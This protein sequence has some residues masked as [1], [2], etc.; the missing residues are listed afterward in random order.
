MPSNLSAWLDH[1]AKIVEASKTRE[2]GDDAQAVPTDDTTGT[3]A[4]TT[5]SSTEIHVPEEWVAEAKVAEV[6]RDESV[7]A[8]ATEANADVAT[9]VVAPVDSAQVLEA[10]AA[11]E[12]GQLPTRIPGATASATAATNDG[13]DPKS[14]PACEVSTSMTVASVFCCGIRSHSRLTTS[15]DASGGR[16]TRAPGSTIRYH[17]PGR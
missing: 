12:A 15:A 16:A 3:P 2:L 7:A 5:D 4:V 1:R 14:P 8:G 6:A 11:E 9:E 13:S 10:P 17:C